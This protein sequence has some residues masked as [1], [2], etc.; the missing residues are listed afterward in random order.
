M[1]EDFSWPDGS[2]LRWN[3]RYSLQ[4]QRQLEQ[5]YFRAPK[6]RQQLSRRLET[7]LVDPR[8]A[9]RSERLRRQ[10]SGL[11]SARFNAADRFIFKLCIECHGY[12]DQTRWPMDCCIGGKLDEARLNMLFTSI[13]HYLDIPTSFD[14]EEQ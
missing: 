13:N 2:R 9:L 12:G 8:S 6:V 4:F 7:L 5:K 14:F 10:Y 11:R 1:P 3:V